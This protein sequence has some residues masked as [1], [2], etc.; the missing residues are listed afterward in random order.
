MFRRSVHEPLITK[1]EIEGA[2]MILMRIDERVEEIYDAL[3]IEEEDD[4]ED[5]EEDA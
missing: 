1:A 2:T 5:S 3:D 4:G